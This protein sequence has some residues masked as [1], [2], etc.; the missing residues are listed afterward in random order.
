MTEH[1]DD[2]ALEDERELPSY[3][4][5]LLDF[6]LYREF[7]LD[8]DW[9]YV[10]RLYQGPEVQFDAYCVHCEKESTFKQYVGSRGSGAGMS[11]PKDQSYLESRII[12]LEFRCQRKAKHQY[13]YILQVDRQAIAKIGQTPSLATIAT[14]GSTRFKK[15]LNKAYVSDLH[16]AIGLFAHG[17]GAGS[18]VY[19]RRIF[20]HL[21]LKAAEDARSIGNPLAGFEELHMDKKINALA[22]HLPPEIV[23]A[24][25]AYSVLSADIHTLSE[26]ECLAL[27]PVM[28]ASIEFILDGH[29]ADKMRRQHQ[30][31]LKR[32]LVDAKAK[33]KTASK[34][35]SK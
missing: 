7:D 28:R 9:S 8:G 1:T 11:L 33:V 15:V 35:R 18:F 10:K 2:A 16:R 30:R 14:A 5:L 23:E 25:G 17:V 34:K 26:E 22:D 27:F 19:L 4:K 3:E 12:D 20:E 24:A 13:H 32:A 6:G 29:L 31:E 21:L